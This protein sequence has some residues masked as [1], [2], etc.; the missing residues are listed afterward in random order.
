MLNVIYEITNLWRGNEFPF[1]CQL[2]IMLFTSCSTANSPRACHVS[3]QVSRFCADILQYSWGGNSATCINLLWIDIFHPNKL[4][5]V[6]FMNFSSS[7]PSSVSLRYHTAPL[8]AH[9]Q[10]CPCSLAS[11]GDFP[12]KVIQ[13][14]QWT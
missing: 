13:V 14:Q 7:L 3:V 10:K 5:S 1:L 8:T 11:S 4:V 12:L 2:V 9:D 6:E